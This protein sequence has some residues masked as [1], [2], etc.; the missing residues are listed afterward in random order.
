MRVRW[1]AIVVAL[2]LAGLMV[3]C[4]HG[5]DRNLRHEFVEE[6]NLPSKDD[7]KFSDPP[8]YPEQKRQLPGPKSNQPPTPGPA[9]RGPSAGP[10]PG[11]P[12]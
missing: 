6:Y 11:T 10:S 8:T 3:G 4:Q 7:R 5:R 1:P 12:Y 9:L 2:G